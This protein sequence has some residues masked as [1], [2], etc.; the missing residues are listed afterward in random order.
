MMKIFND[1]SRGPAE[2]E[3]IRKGI[4]AV[5]LTDSLLF[6]WIFVKNNSK[7]DFKKRRLK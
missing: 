5:L 3:A 7:Y 6:G 4:L 1:T 2:K